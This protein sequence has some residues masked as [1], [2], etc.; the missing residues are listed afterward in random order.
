V[1]ISAVSES[2]E[3]SV[4]ERPDAREMAAVRRPRQGENDIAIGRE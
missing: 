2:K 1:L 4:T 3:Q